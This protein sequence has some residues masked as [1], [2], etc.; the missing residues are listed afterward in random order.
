MPQSVLAASEHAGC[1]CEAAPSGA[2]CD[3]SAEVGVEV[4]LVGPGPEGPSPLA[5]VEA[6]SLAGIVGVSPAV[7]GW[8][9]QK[10]ARHKMAP[11]TPAVPRRI[12]AQ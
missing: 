10:K 1:A 11:H 6:F 12:P 4:L 2:P 3:I 8:V 5:A 7:Q 9:K